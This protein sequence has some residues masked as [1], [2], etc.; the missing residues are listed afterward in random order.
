[1]RIIHLDLKLS[2]MDIDLTEHWV[3]FLFYEYILACWSHTIRA[4]Q[5][6]LMPLYCFSSKSFSGENKPRVPNVVGEWLALLLRIR[7]VLSSNL[8]PV[9]GY[10]D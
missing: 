5:D 9:I 2:S 7:E 10:R 4:L 6:P 3:C 1:M 8:G